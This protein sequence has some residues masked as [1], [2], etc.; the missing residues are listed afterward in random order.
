M[1]LEHVEGVIRHSS[2]KLQVF[3]EAI[4]SLSQN[5]LN[6]ISSIAPFS[7]LY[8]IFIAILMLFSVIFEDDKSDNFLRGDKFF[9]TLRRTKSRQKQNK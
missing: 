7:C 2:T 6:K 1:I 4:H 9:R 5:T 8:Y 3:G